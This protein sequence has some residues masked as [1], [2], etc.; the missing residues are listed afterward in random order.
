MG[1]TENRLKWIIDFLNGRSQRA[2]VGAAYSKAIAMAS[3]IVQG[4]CIG[5]I[6]F[7]IYV[8]GVV[9]CFDDEFV[10]SLYA[11]DVELCIYIW[12][13]SDCSRLHLA[14]DRLVSWANKWQL[15]ITMNKC[16]VSQV[17]NNSARLIHIAFR[18]DLYQSINQ[19]NSIYNAPYVASY[20][21]ARERRKQLSIIR[22]VI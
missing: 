4:S 7:V 15:R 16:M 13:L 19:S 11:D 1:L 12:S 17:G 3:G 21:W 2:S 18:I 20:S 6:L 10:C 5:P 9:G 22:E 8:N 14:I